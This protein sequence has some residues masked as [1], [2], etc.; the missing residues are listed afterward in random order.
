MSKCVFLEHHSNGALFSPQEFFCR[1]CKQIV[2]EQQMTEKCIGDYLCCEF[3][4]NKDE[5]L[6]EKPDE[7]PADLEDRMKY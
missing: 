1:L 4:C 7:E 5:P 6:C 2:S 3:Y